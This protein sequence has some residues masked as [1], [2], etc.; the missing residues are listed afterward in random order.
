[1]DNKNVCTVCG[2]T[3]I[4][5][6]TRVACPH[7]KGSGQLDTSVFSCHYYPEVEVA[8]SNSDEE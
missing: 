4:E 8:Y 7:C 3:G 1:M 6:G 2:G 5:P